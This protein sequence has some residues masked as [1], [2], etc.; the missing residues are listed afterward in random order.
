MVKYEDGGR[1][2]L[3]DV[4]R[5]RK[6][7]WRRRQ[8]TFVAEG[9]RFLYQALNSRAEI[10]AILYAPAIAKSPNSRKLI[11]SAKKRGIACYSICP[12]EYYNAS[13]ASEPDGIISVVSQSWQHLPSPPANGIYLAVEAIESPGN[14]GSIIRTAAAA[15]VNGLIFLGMS[16]DPYDPISVRATMGA[17]YCVPMMRCS[18]SDLASWCARVSIAVIGT[19]PHARISY[20]DYIYPLNSVLLLG[21]ERRGMSDQV[22]AICTDTVRIPM[23]RGIDS[24]NVSVAAGILLFE[25]SKNFATAG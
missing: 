22:S 18:V 4:V 1:S 21:S 11:D 24:L 3:Q 12:D 16:S 10:K 9:M 5:L 15:G 25:A 6:P 20:Q 19:S 17:I 2:I 23:K 7:E 8:R 13:L 14:L